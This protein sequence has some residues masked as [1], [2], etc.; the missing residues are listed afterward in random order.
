LLVGRGDSCDVVIDDDSI[1]RRHL[2]IRIDEGRVAVEDLESTNGLRVGGEVVETASLEFDR[3]FVAGAVML[4]VRR[5]VSLT[6]DISPPRDTPVH[7]RPRADSTLTEGPRTRPSIDSEGEVLQ[8]LIARLR[9]VRE[10]EQVLEEL[11]DHLC[12]SEG[13]EGA[14]LIEAPGEADVLA[15]RYLARRSP[16]D[17]LE[18]AVHEFVLDPD[19]APSSERR[20]FV[21]CPVFGPG[22]ER[23]WLVAYPLR[24]GREPSPLMRFSAAIAGRWLEGGVPADREKRGRLD[25]E[26]SPAPRPGAPEPVLVGVSLALRVMLDEVDRLARTELPL[27]VH[28]E[29]GT[30]KEL[31][32]RRLHARSQRGAGPFFAI[33]CSALPRELLEAELFGIERGVATGVEP[34]PGRF[35]LASGGT[36]LLDEV[37]DLPLEL[38]P[39]LLRALESSEILPLG[40]PKPV[41]VDVRIVAATHQDLEE[42]VE[43]GRFRRDL[44]HRIAGAVIAV[45]PLRERPEDIIPLAREFAGRIARASGLP[46]YGLDL[47]TARVLLGYPWPGNVRELQHVMARACALAEDAMLHPALLPPALAENADGARADA[48]LGLREDYRTARRGFERLYFAQLLERC[49]GNLSE[50]ARRAELTRGHLYKKLEELGL[51]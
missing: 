35:A 3:W 17:G 13:F 20:D 40:A 28:G 34:R 4:A 5:G 47:A 48:Y 7:A 31:V 8:R 46:G 38:Q 44:Y 15:L 1:S 21:A 37:G 11:L 16:D 18:K 12:E 32:A 51:R 25:L 30:G 33:N 50:A 49:K 43:K 29:S 36:L 26:N 42:M 45:P 9:D 2:K 27:L 41:S 14:M 24:P 19:R 6:P 39:K 22:A 10:P 23:G